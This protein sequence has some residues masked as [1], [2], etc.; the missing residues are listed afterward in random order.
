MVYF[1]F[2]QSPVKQPCEYKHLTLSTF[3]ALLLVLVSN[4]ISREESKRNTLC[5]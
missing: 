4:Y 3:Y 1:S 2:F 5:S